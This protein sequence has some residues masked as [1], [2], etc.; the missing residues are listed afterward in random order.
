MENELKDEIQKIKD[1]NI[2]VGF[3][4]AWEISWTRRILILAI[5][6]IV[7]STWLFVIKETNVFLKALIPTVGYLLSTLS[8]SQL[9]KLWIN[10]QL[11]KKQDYIKNHP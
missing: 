5:T 7:S 2:R 1:R 8:I 9:K 11:S 4:K 6:F 10:K 3:D